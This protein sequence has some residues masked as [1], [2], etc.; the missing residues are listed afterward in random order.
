M[1]E[2][3]RFTVK[4]EQGE[5]EYRIYQETPEL[6]R[7]YCV[8]DSVSE[9]HP[10]RL[11]LVNSFSKLIV[12]CDGKETVE[13]VQGMEIPPYFNF[14]FMKSDKAATKAALKLII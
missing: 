4:N 8:N 7:L 11:R 12:T 5:F 10:E 2:I 3:R 14:T 9:E 1:A 6:Y 13:F